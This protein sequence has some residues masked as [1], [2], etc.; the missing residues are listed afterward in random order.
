MAADMLTAANH[1]AAYRV[2]MSFWQQPELLVPGAREQSTVYS[3]PPPWVCDVPQW[4]RM[5]L[6]DLLAY[7][8]DD[9]LTKVDRASMVVG[10]EARVPLLDHRV[11]EFCYGLPEFAVRDGRSGKLP[12]RRLLGRYLPQSL[13]NRPKSGFSVPLGAW[14]RGP[15]REWA[16]DLL[17]TDSLLATG[18]IDPQPVQALL[19]RHLQTDNDCSASLW[20]VLMFQAWHQGRTAP[21]ISFAPV[22]PHTP[23]TVPGADAAAGTGAV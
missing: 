15:L 23:G 5:S 13:V 20:C 14:L 1:N 8:P 19:R 17:S 21:L 18:V 22:T 4:R 11:V 6:M 12:L 16:Q 3:S 9:C 7:L 2:L 10:L